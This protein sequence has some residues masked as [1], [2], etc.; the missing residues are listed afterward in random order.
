MPW[1]I[2]TWVTLSHLKRLKLFI[3]LKLLTT[4]FMD[5]Y[6]HLVSPPYLSSSRNENKDR[7][8]FIKPECGKFYWV[9][10]ELQCEGGG[11]TI[12][13]LPAMCEKND[14]EEHLDF[15]SMS[16]MIYIYIYTLESRI[17]VP[18]R[19]LTSRFFST[20]DIF[21]PTPP[22]INFQSF[23]LTFLRE[24]SNFHHSPS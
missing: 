16:Q 18:P 8:K 24:N 3:I 9:R 6:F 7:S 15:C 2:G 10:Y 12:K 19:L 23:L 5:I 20:Q 14:L 21:I 1:W 17:I 11:T 22:I 4:K 13:V